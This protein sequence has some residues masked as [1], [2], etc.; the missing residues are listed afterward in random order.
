MEGRITGDER[1]EGLQRCLHVS[2]PDKQQLDIRQTDRSEPLCESQ[3]FKDPEKKNTVT[4][5]N[6]QSHTLCYWSLS[7]AILF[8]FYDGLFNI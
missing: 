2:C 4:E 1:S 5:T 6:W 3:M 8:V 7:H